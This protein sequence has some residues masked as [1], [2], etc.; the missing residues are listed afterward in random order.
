MGNPQDGLA[1]TCA[2]IKMCSVIGAVSVYIEAVSFALAIRDSH[3]AP[4][5]HADMIAKERRK[6]KELVET[7]ALARIKEGHR[8]LL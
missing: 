3:G 1:W 6:E 7:D 2:K 5:S 8:M 4:L